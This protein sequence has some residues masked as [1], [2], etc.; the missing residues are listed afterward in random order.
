[1]ILFETIRPLIFV[2]SFSF[3]F[4]LELLFS[5]RKKKYERKQRWP[6]NLGL[7]VINALLLIFIFPITSIEWANYVAEMNWSPLFSHSFKG[8]EVFLFLMLDFAIYLQHIITHK[9]PLLWRFHKTHHIDSDLDV[10]SGLRFHPVEII[11]SQLYKMVWIYLLGPNVMTVFLFEVFLNS[12]AMFNH[13]NL[14]IPPWFEKR[15]R[16][17]IVTP[18]MHLIHHSVEQFESDTN[19]GFQLSLWDRVFSTY[20]D[21]FKSNG[22]IGQRGFEKAEDQKLMNLLLNPFRKFHQKTQ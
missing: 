19:F 11:F 15:L 13:S 12:M 1:M 2:L 14:Y 4:I 3:L 5:Y 7:T 9:V 17:L 8:K 10:S 18:Q 21:H 22:D 16:Y 20:T 6:G